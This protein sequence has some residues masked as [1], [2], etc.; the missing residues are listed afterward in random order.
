MPVVFSVAGPA[1][2]VVPAASLLAAPRGEALWTRTVT[3]WRSFPSRLPL[4]LAA[5]LLLANAALLGTNGL[6]SRRAAAARI[7]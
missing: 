5:L 3:A 2:L 6:L 1:R 7:D 4:L